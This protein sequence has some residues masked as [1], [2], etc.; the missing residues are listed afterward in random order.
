MRLSQSAKVRHR[1]SLRSRLRRLAALRVR[2][3][4]HI[5]C[6]KLSLRKWKE[7]DLCMWRAQ[8]L[9]C[10]ALCQLRLDSPCKFFSGFSRQSATI[11]QITRRERQTSYSQKKPCEEEKARRM[12]LPL[13]VK[14][15]SVDRKPANHFLSKKSLLWEFSLKAAFKIM[16]HQK[17]VYFLRVSRLRL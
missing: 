3:K 2:C 10:R 13:L 4:F 17:N 12:K 7:V 11:V 6:S 16:H 15:D 5:L 1:R 9:A 14:R 8:Q